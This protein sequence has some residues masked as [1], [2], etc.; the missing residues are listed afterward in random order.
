MAVMSRVPAGEGQAHAGNAGTIGPIALP[1]I[2]CA[3]GR[4]PRIAGTLGTVPRVTRSPAAALLLAA[5][6]LLAGCGGSAIPVVSFD[7]VAAC[8]TDGRMPGAYPEL[9]VLLPSAYQGSA[10]INV[11]SGRNCTPEALGTLADAGLSEVRFAGATWDLG[12]SAALTR[13]LFEADGLTPSAMIDFYK[14]GALTNRKTERLADAA[15][16]VD[17]RAGRR[18]DVLQADG[19]AQTIVAWPAAEPGRVN[20]LLASDVGDTRVLEALEELAGP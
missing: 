2:G 6:A 13:A 10:P 16:T 18:L 5:A 9:E 20:V 1:T 3:P 12:G 11:D 14:A 17:G 15:T 4:C 19:T 8:T 7:P